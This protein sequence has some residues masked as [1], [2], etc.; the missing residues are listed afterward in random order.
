MIQLWHKGTLVGLTKTYCHIFLKSENN[1]IPEYQNSH[2]HS[3]KGNVHVERVPYRSP[4]V[5]MFIVAGV[6]LGLQKDIDYTI[7]Q[8]YGGISRFQITTINGRRV[9]TNII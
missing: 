8:E 2:F 9:N 7:N 3:Q 5:D 6:D 4:I 1:S